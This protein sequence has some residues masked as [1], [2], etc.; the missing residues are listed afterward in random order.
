[1]MSKQFTASGLRS[2]ADHCATEAVN[3]KQSGADIERL[4][5]MNRALH[6]MARTRD[7]LEGNSGVL[8]EFVLPAGRR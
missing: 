1:M 5:K 2:W 7:W 3:G 4:W 6:D 8:V